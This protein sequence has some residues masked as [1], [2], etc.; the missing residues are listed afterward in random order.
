VPATSRLTHDEREQI[1]LSDLETHF[2]DFAGPSLSWTK[3]PQGQDPPDFLSASQRGNHG[4][5]L[6]E[7]LDGEQMTAAKGRES[8][9]DQVHR[10]LAGNWENEYRPKHFRGAF[11]A[12]GNERISRADEV[13]LRKQFFEHAAEIDGAWLTNPERTGNS[14]YVTEFPGYPLMAKYF[15]VRYIGG[16]PHGLCW[17]HR[18]ATEGHMIPWR[19]LLP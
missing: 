10:I 1:V 15:H 16:E 9:H 8:Q 13:P 7:W 17:I 2:P 3:V 11:L 6:T 5:E 18:R 14:L 4:L 19:L 12:I